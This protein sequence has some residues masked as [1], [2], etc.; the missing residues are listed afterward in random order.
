MQREKWNKSL[1]PD[2]L[3]GFNF[4]IDIS[5]SVTLDY[6]CVAGCSL[7]AIYNNFLT[8]KFMQR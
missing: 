7:E 4:S 8:N 5:L 1:W 3:E 2:Y 6:L